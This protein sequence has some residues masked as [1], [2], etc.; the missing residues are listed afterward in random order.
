MSVDCI[1]IGDPHV[2]VSN[3]QDVEVLIKKLIDL[4]SGRKPKFVVLAGDILHDHERLHTLAL[5]KA[6]EL[7]NEL[8]SLVLTYVLV[9]NHDYVNNQQFLTDNHWMNPLKEWN[10][11]VI[12]D[13]VISHIINDHLFTFVPYVP[14]GRFE[15]ALNTSDVSWKESSCIFAHQ[16]FAGCKMGAITSIEG[17]NW[18][19]EY[20]KVISGHIH[21]KQSPQANIYYPGSALQIA[22][23]ESEK[24]I[25]SCLDFMENTYNLEEIDLDLP[26]KKIIYM[27]IM[28]IDEY[29]Y[30]K[31]DDRIRLTLSGNHDEF[32]AFKK[33]K[34]Y[35][36][37][38]SEDIK[39]VFKPKKNK[40]VVLGNV[41][42][43]TLEHINENDS[44]DFKS[45]LNSIVVE[46]KDPYLFQ[47]YELVVN[48]KDTCS[49]DVFFI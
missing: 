35:K 1:F 25:V 10:N 28:D 12:V 39:I 48:G 49:D 16:E 47:A 6:L 36:D 29:K 41:D 43:K 45:I 31:T 3:I 19:L 40:K 32:K 23:G 46:N 27:D 4:I 34:K 15:E 7:I 20:P 33:T 21:S 8:R 22:F 42:E 9:G 44:T 37:L 5:N 26:R 30:K 24:N 17:D 13:K 11:V 2:Q 18:S 38:T 14:P